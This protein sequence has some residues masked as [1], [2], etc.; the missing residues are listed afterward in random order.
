MAE[1]EKKGDE[2][3]A[4]PA[5]PPQS[6]RQS[7]SRFALIF[8]GILAI[9]AF[10]FPDVGRELAGGAGAILF[11]LIGFG[12]H[13]PVITILIGGLLTTTISGILRHFMTPWVK[14]AKM[15]KLS[16][17]LSKESMEAMR[18]GN[19]SKAQ[20]L[21]E[22][23]MEMM[24]QYSN[25]QWVTLKQLAAT[26]LLFIVFY[27]WLNLDFMQNVLV[28]AGNVYFSVPWSWNTYYFD[29]YLLP[30]W[31]LLYSLLAIPFGQVLQR[32]LKYFSFRRRLEEL[33]ALSE[34]T[35]PEDVP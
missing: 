28:P 33:G 34:M 17:A 16:Q 35:A 6:L 8:L 32:V 15:N 19:L 31:L 11:P 9:Y 25:I 30:V 20:K 26:F 2:A 27:T 18:K 13:Y 5:R 14:M 1:P 7:L 10:L 23:R 21:R 12:G 29:A 4:P 3:P 22:K 24:A